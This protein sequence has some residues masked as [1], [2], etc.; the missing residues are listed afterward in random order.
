M[1]VSTLII[2]QNISN[3]LRKDIS[4]SL[5]QGLCILCQIIMASFCW[6]GKMGRKHWLASSW[7]AGV[8]WDLPGSIHIAPHIHTPRSQERRSFTQ[9]TGSSNNAS[10]DQMA[11][12]SPM[13]DS[14]AYMQAY[15]TLSHNLPPFFPSNESTATQCLQMPIQQIQ[16][17]SGGFF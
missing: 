15:H 17:S 4:T 7:G 3:S 13:R 16:E 10:A 11:S 1:G 12:R 14:R 9:D 2:A 8:S 5:S 6:E